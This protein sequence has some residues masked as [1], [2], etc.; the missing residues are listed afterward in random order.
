MSDLTIGLVGLPFAG[1]TI[2]YRLLSQQISDDVHP[3]P[4]IKPEKSVV[5]TTD[6]RVTQIADIIK[7]PEIFPVEIQVVDTAGL[8][9]DNSNLAETYANLRE[10][11][12]LLYI[13]RAFDSD[14]V[15]AMKQDYQEQIKNIDSMIVASDLEILQ[16][17]IQR[18]RKSP[19]NRK[20]A[21]QELLEVLSSAKPLREVEWQQEALTEIDGLN[22]LSFK[23]RVFFINTGEEQVDELD[24]IRQSAL[25]VEE[26]TEKNTT[27]LCGQI[28]Y[29]MQQ[30]PPDEREEYIS[31]YGD[32][33]LIADD[34]SWIVASSAEMVTYYT[35]GRLGL[36]QWLVPIGG[37][38]QLAAKRLHSDIAKGLVATEVFT[39]ED[40]ILLGSESEVKSKGKMRVEG[41]DY[42]IQ[43]GD[44][45]YFRTSA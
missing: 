3:F 21:L 13:I 11:D 4:T 20:A 22:L 33:K 9:E 45:L 38:A 1:K 39:A 34:L 18:S 12:L 2:V 6:D 7:P 14:Q 41:R 25:A 40:L 29:E 15:P 10:C 26:L 36:K 28:E 30:V 5:K 35:Y 23:P 43:D 37:K 19:A 17:E 42:I 16:R 24:D 8:S 32:I 44:I 27:V 31:M